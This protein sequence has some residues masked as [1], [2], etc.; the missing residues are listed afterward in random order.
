LMLGLKSL[1]RMSPRFLK[2]GVNVDAVHWH[3]TQHQD[4]TRMNK[5]KHYHLIV[6][7]RSIWGFVCLCVDP[8]CLFTLCT[9]AEKVLN[10]SGRST[11]C[12]G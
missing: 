12:S 9:C 2:D 6:C 10:S 5:R 3:F 1:R 8:Q 7:S 11:W 4:G